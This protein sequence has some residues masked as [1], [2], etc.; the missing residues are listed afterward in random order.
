MN[1]TSSNIE[2]LDSFLQRWQTMIDLLARLS[3]MPYAMINRI[4]GDALMV[5]TLNS[6]ASGFAANDRFELCANT[7]CARA[8]KQGSPLLVEDARERPEMHDNPT[9][10][11]G[12]IAYYGLPIRE[13]DG[14]LFGTLCILDSQPRRPDEASM[15]LIEV[16]RDSIEHDLLLLRQNEALA[17]SEAAARA[18]HAEAEQAHRGKTEFLARISHELRTPLGAVLG[19][20]QLLEFDAAPPLSPLQRSRVGHI[21]QAGQHLLAL[22]DDTLDLSKLEVGQLRLRLAP[23][24]LATVL[25]SAMD[26]SSHEA[27]R[28]RVALQRDYV[29]EA[30]PHVLTDEQR[31]RQVL[32]NLISNA[33]KYRR[34]GGRVSVQAQ[35]V[36]AGVRIEIRDDGIGMSAEQLSHLF[37]PFNRLG[38]E[39]SAV[40]GTGLGLALSQQ[41]MQLMGGDIAVH[42]EAGLGTQVVLRLPLAAA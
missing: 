6:G 5:Q 29:G 3:A 23:T 12:L 14:R 19:F 30:L 1:A 11:F 4:D 36:P 17:A 31:L 13:F 39:A 18:A 8:L 10:L 24:E 9:A 7:Y 38:R 37:E 25:D 33:I 42:S 21:Y 32:L 22:I 15:Q 41:L 40:D 27:Q 20:A 34:E 28:Q 16:M 35:P 26:L 2:G